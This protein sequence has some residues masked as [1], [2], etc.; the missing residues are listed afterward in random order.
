MKVCTQCDIEYPATEIYFGADKRNNNN[1]LQSRCRKCDSAYQRE[2]GRRNR[3]KIQG[4]KKRYVKT[5]SGRAS[6]IMRGIRQRCYD[7]NVKDYK[8]YGGKGITVEFTHRE[9]MDRLSDRNID[10]RNLVIHRKNNNKN[11]SLDN[12]EFLTKKEHNILHWNIRKA[13]QNV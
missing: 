2:Y 1:G 12:I 11:Y 13:V 3:N 7:P 9:L 10:P 6:L 8:Y 4:Q 5:T